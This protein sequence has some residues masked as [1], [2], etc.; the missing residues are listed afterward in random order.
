MISGGSRAT[1]WR[2]V[3]SGR[4]FSI[5]RRGPLIGDCEKGDRFFGRCGDWVESCT[6]LVEDHAGAL[7]QPPNAIKLSS[8][9]SFPHG[10][11]LQ[12]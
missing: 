8:E 12:V 10:L 9:S 11:P 2:H 4:G 7:I 1:V 5:V 6:A 3:G